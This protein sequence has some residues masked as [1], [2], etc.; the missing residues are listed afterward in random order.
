MHIQDYVAAIIFGAV[1]GIVARILLPGRQ[2]IG[3]ILTVLIGMVAA[4]IGTWLADKWD[5]YSSKFVHVAGRTFDWEVVGVQVGV[6]IVGIALAALLARA[7]TIDR[8]D[9]R[10]HSR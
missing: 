2:R 6:A 1:I 8:E 4:V 9:S 3:I 7:F 10:H 5:T